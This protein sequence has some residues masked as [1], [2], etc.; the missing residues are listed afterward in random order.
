MKLF[1]KKKTTFITVEIGGKAYDYP[2]D[3]PLP[4][5]GEVVSMD[6]SPFGRVTRILYQINGDDFRMISIDT[7]VE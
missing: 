7:D 1:K 6:G 4:R 2:K 3:M 5:I